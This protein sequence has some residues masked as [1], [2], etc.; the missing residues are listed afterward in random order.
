[1]RLGS[2]GNR[3]WKHKRVLVTGYEGF[4][5][6][7]LTKALIDSGAKVAGL[8]IKTRRKH[9]ILRNDYEKLTIINGSVENLNLLSK[10]LDTYKID[11]VFHLA[12]A[13]LVGESLLD[14]LVAFSTNIKGTWNCLEACRRYK[15]IKGVIL[16]SSD[17]AY[18]EKNVLPYKENASLN[19]DHPYDASKSCADLLAYTYFNTYGLPVCVTRCGNIFGPGDFNFSRI[20]PDAIKSI[21]LNKVLQVRSNGKFTRDYVYVKDIV[22]AYLF[23]AQKMRNLKLYGEAFNFSNESPITVVELIKLIAK[24][25]K[26]KV[27]Y[28]I[29]NQAQ[30]E[31]KHQYLCAAKARKV[32]GWRPKYSLEQGLKETIEWYQN[33]LSEDQVGK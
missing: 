27:N 2:S 4:L 29:L 31:I 22:S 30:F 18:G 17:K 20:I 15:R 1:M 23:L 10:I 26:C 6:S 11:Y 24:I 33:Y 19:G 12:A 14:P 7:H 21:V 9:T 16:A 25:A 32:L 5:G 13:A 8:D 3:F 28:K